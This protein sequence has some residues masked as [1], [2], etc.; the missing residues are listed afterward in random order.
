MNEQSELLI[1][2]NEAT[3]LVFYQLVKALIDM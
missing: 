2:W 3:E 1:N